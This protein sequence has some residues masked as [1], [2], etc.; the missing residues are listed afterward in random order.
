MKILK[1]IQPLGPADSLK[2]EIGLVST[3]G[4]IDLLA[5]KIRQ[6]FNRS[7]AADNIE[8]SP[9]GNP[10]KLERHAFTVKDA[11]HIAGDRYKMRLAFCHHG[12]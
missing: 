3:K 10:H 5:F 12:P 7:I 8:Y 11:C 9:D 4:D 1:W 6:G 2:H